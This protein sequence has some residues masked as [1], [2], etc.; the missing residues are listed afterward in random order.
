MRSRIRTL[1]TRPKDKAI[2]IRCLAAP[3]RR[4]SKNGGA[5]PQSR[6]RLRWSGGANADEY[7][8]P[9]L[10][11]GALQHSEHPTT[12][13]A[14][15]SREQ[16][17]ALPRVERQPGDAFGPSEGSSARRTEPQSHE[18]AAEWA[19]SRLRAAALMPPSLARA[20]WH[21]RS[22]RT[23]RPCGASRSVCRPRPG[24]CRSPV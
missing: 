16:H 17:I 22:R 12:V 2:D 21:R 19:S 1:R 7:R 13:R 14:R 11:P 20:P 8:V 4:L 10:W 5:R 18:R 3:P 15:H 6:C 24:R 23:A 9:A